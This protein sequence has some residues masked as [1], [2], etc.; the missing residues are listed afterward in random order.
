M[1]ELYD[2]KTEYLKTPVGVDAASPRFSWKLK[3]DR[4]NVK[5]QSY[6]IHV[7][8]NGSLLWDSGEICSRETFAI[9]YSG[10]PL[11]KGERIVWTLSAGDGTETASGESFFE[12]ALLASTDWEAEWIRP[13]SEI[14]FDAFKPAARLRREFSVKPGL[15]R[16][17]AC[18]SAH[19]LYTFFINGEAGTEEKFT[20]GITSYYQRVQYQTSD[21]TALVHEGVNCWAV[22]LGDGWWRGYTG[23]GNRNNFGFYTAFI[24][25]LILD[26]AD[27]SREILGT[28]QHFR[29][30][31][32]AITRCDMKVGEVYDARIA[33]SAWRMPGYDD[34]R[35]VAV[36]PGNEYTGLDALFPS[37]S[38]PVL[39]RERFAGRP[40]RDRAG[41]LVIDFGQNHTGYVRMTLRNTV[42]GQ[43]LTLWYGEGLK[44]GTFSTENLEETSKDPLQQVVYICRGSEEETYQPTFSVFGY[45]YVKLEGYDEG[46]IR[47]GDFT[48]F[49][50]YSALEET[51]SF[52]C[53]NPLV[54]QL[55]SNSRWSQ[56]SNFLDA[57]TDCP[58]RERSLWSGDGQVYCRTAADFMSVYP[59]YEKWLADLSLEQFESG[60]VGNTFPSTNALH[61]AEER[62]RMIEQGRFVFAPP[63]MAGPQGDGDFMDGAAGWG[64]VA[65]IT[66]WTMYL[67]Y[68]DSEILKRQYPAAKKWVDFCRRNAKNHN[69]LYED[70]PEYHRM[71]DGV[72]DADYLYDTHFH[73][74]EWLEPDAPENGGSQA[75]NPMEFAKNGNP[76]VATA[77]L[78]YSS[79]LLAKMAEV[80]GLSEDMA[81]YTS[82][83]ANVKRVYNQ[84]LIGADGTILKDRQAPY[85]RTL[86]FQLAD[87]EN[88]PKICQK[89]AEAVENADFTV[90][91]GFLSTPFLLKMLADYVSPDYAYR[92]LEQT[93]FPSWLHPVTLGAT[94]ILENWNGLDIYGGSFNHYSYGA[95][96]D[97]LFSY[98]AGIR[99]DENA[100]GYRH[101]ILKPIPGGTL[102]WAEAVFQSPCGEI[103]A[104]WKKEGETIRYSFTVPAN[105][106]A[107]LF[108]PGR[109][110]QEL[111]S[112]SYT[113]EEALG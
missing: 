48:S 32:S 59:F 23:G 73:W 89:L 24:G 79:T 99:M 40:F 51:G 84:Y 5:Q 25:E 54:N 61:N 52:T 15:V 109:A 66:P 8:A 87:E 86:A 83:A 112:G 67:C 47:P 98:T 100:P 70:R 3:S 50:V 29:T 92:M 63:T 13:E 33:S 39:E 27:G 55:V 22:L 46:R 42:A 85:V 49:A 68:G 74:G 56:K 21:I 34:S 106:T 36:L 57:P 16:A 97:F 64:D 31:P 88:L 110:P 62:R 41:N 58:T 71:A 102:T 82:Y 78:Y 6:R 18:Q 60:C 95:V 12:T 28:D 103:R 14:D 30:A 44:D 17:R 104:A 90:N 76:A 77:Y 81:E 11:P 9:P 38:V 1:L 75:F 101:F 43:T 2:L 37:R 96:C 4:R 111:G 80:L 93:K 10:A 19:G 107:T 20:P 72:L 105:T 91:T 7:A 69:P 94:T 45:R 53:S 65:T 26:Y 108:L 113:F 35:W